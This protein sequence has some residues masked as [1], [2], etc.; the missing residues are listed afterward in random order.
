M[1]QALDSGPYFSYS[2]GSDRVLFWVGV[3]K[4]IF[5]TRYWGPPSIGQEHFVTSGGCPSLTNPAGLIRAQDT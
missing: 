3:T 1:A 4:F 5:R 2:I